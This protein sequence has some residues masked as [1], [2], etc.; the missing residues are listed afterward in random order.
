[1]GCL[2]TLPRSKQLN[3]SYERAF[4]ANTANHEIDVATQQNIWAANQGTAEHST[5][6]VQ[7]IM[8]EKLNNGTA[9]A[10]VPTR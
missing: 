10:H 3:L 6:S 4:G 2:R 1:V 7:P 5:T 8:S 9:I